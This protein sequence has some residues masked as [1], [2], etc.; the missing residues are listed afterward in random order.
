MGEKW[1]DE[2]L[3]KY[4][5]KNACPVKLKADYGELDER[6][7]LPI[8]I[9]HIKNIYTFTQLNEII[10]KSNAS[11]DTTRQKGSVPDNCF[12]LTKYKAEILE[13]RL[14]SVLQSNPYP[15]G[16][17]S[18]D[19]YSKF[20]KSFYKE[21][22]KIVNDVSNVSLYVQ[23]SSVNG[24][25]WKDKNRQSRLFCDES[26]Y[27][28]GIVS[29]ALYIDGKAKQCRE[30]NPLCSKTL[31]SVAIREDGTAGMEHNED[32]KWPEVL[33]L[34]ETSITCNLKNRIAIVI[35]GNEESAKN[36]SGCAI[37]TKIY[38]DK[39]V[40]ILHGTLWD[41]SKTRSVTI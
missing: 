37:V 6:G 24:F 9:E 19:E 32:H 27:D 1:E 17:E 30:V 21:L 35:Y 2:V 18:H 10:S 11:A 5:N 31:H 13:N 28:I 38:N 26:D 16:F 8:Y 34:L 39:V 41:V 29:E 12:E 23:G 15:L 33:P 3:S 4:A 40:S 7:A 36:H 20:I 25:T 14:S 22:A